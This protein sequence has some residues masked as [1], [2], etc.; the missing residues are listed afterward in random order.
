VALV[1]CGIVP[2]LGIGSRCRSAPESSPTSAIISRSR[3][4]SRPSAR[5]SPR[6]ARSSPARTGAPGAAR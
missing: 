5:I 2:P 3:P 1:Q 6:C 4:T